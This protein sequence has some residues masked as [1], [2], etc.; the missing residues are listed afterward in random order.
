MLERSYCWLIPRAGATALCTM[1]CTV[2]REIR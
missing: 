1:L 2:P